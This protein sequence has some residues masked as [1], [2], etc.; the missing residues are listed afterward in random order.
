[1][2]A[3]LV[4]ADQVRHGKPHPEGYLAAAAR[5]GVDPTRCNV[6]EDTPPGNEAAHAARMRAVAIA[7]TC[8]PEALATANLVVPEL[9]SLRI[10]LSPL[11]TGLHLAVNLPSTRR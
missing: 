7:S 9:S 11:G 5:L 2:P 3:V 4:T 1:M 8:R 6:I 10:E